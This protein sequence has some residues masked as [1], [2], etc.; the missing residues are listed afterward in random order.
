MSVTAT[1]PAGEADQAGE[2]TVRRFVTVLA[3]TVSGLC[4]A[5]SAGNVY[6]LAVDLQLWAWIRPL[7]APAVDLSL[8]A[9]LVGIRFLAIRGVGDREL[10]RPRLFLLAVGLAAWALNTAGA[11]A[12]RD[13]GKAAFD[14]LAPGLLVGWAE[15]LPWFLRQFHAATHPAAEAEPGAVR[16]PAAAADRD[17]TTGTVP[18]PGAEQAAA[19]VVPPPVPGGGEAGARPIPVED[20]AGRVR[21]TRR[22]RPTGTREGAAASAGLPERARTVAAAFAAEHGR[23]ISRDALGRALHV[24]NRVAGELLRAVR[25]APP[26]ASV[27]PSVVASAVPPRAAQP[28]PGPVAGPAAGNG[29]RPAPSSAS[30]NPTGVP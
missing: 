30:R 7:V 28:R 5:F 6:Q 16:V 23:P 19:G 10:R 3:V 21:R 1:R 4:F 26:P 17:A 9:L 12:Q 14:S 2:R 11:V 20:D 13:W 29:H 24:G 18:A 22:P 25:E 8:V 15:V 27:P